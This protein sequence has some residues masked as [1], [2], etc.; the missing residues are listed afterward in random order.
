MSYSDKSFSTQERQLLKKMVGAALESIDAVIVARGD[1]SWNTVRLHFNG[2]SI[3]VN[4]RLGEIVVDEFGT[5]DEFGLLSIAE[6]A[7]EKLDIPEASPN[8]TTYQIGKP[9]RSVEVLSDVISVFGDGIE[10]A[11]IKYPQ[12]IVM[13][14]GDDFIVL[15]KEVWFSEMI[16]LKRGVSADELLYDDSINWEDNHEEDPGTHFEFSTV[17]EE[18]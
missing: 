7:S 15:D 13:G 11:T 5:L 18:I 17:F 1:C 4:N 12:A 3:D 2:F 8:T 6:T 16:A 14:V 9:V 10:V